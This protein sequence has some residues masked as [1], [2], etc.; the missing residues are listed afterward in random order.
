MKEIKL[1]RVQLKVLFEEKE[2]IL[3]RPK[4]GRV[5]HFEQVIEKAEPMVRLKETLDLLESCGL[6]RDIAEN[7][8]AEL[9][10]EV[11]DAL[12]PGKKN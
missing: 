7:M 1:Q 9:V 10:L 5:F 12:K 2:Y 3:T 8:D 4:M 6:P 11:L